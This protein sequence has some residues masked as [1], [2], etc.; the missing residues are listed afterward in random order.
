MLLHLLDSAYEPNYVD[1][2]S[3]YVEYSPQRSYVEEDGE[4]TGLWNFDATL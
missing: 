3:K 1:K 2:K 4:S